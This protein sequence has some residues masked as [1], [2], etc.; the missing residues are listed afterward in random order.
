MVV[1]CLIQVSLQL[2]GSPEIAVRVGVVRGDLDRLPK[3]VDRALQLV[4]LGQHDSEVVV[5]HR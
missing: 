1:D 4:L 2:K 3:M 5:D